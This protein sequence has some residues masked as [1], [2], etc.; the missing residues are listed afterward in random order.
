MDDESFESPSLTK[1]NSFVSQDILDNISLPQVLRNQGKTALKVS[2]VT[3]V[4]SLILILIDCRMGTRQIDRAGQV[5]TSEQLS[6]MNPSLVSW[7]RWTP[8]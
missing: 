6:Q 1:R 2:F 7:T 4:Q 8:S 5:L 3:F